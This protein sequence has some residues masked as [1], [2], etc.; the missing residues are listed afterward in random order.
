MIRKEDLSQQ[1]EDAITECQINCDNEKVRGNP[2]GI[3]HRDKP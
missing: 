1:L 3:A 2:S